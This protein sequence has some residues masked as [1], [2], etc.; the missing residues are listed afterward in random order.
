M[1][2]ENKVGKYLEG[3][4]NNDYHGDKDFLSSSQV[5]KAI[6]SHGNFN[7]YIN[8]NEPREKTIDS[9]LDQ[10]TLIHSYL[11]EPETIDTD[12]AFMDDDGRNWRTKVDR[13]YKAQFLSAAGSK[14]VMSYTA[15]KR[16]ER[17]AKSAMAHPFF[18]RLLT[19]DGQPEMSG[20][21]T[22]DFY[23]IDL[24]FRPD[25]KI[26]EIDGGPAILDVKS[27]ANIEDFER[28]AKY[29]FDYDL[30]CYLYLL[31]NHKV[32]GEPM[33]IPF[34]FGV[35]ES[36]GLYRSAVYK[37]S[38][39]FIEQGRKKYVKAMSNIQIA[40]K[41]KQDIVVFQDCDYQNI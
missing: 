26:F 23:N 29:Q 41:Q 32:T 7:Y 30:S 33:D 22:D 34:Y 37:A 5:K 40:K 1:K 24:R 6:K 11:L 27:T 18:K 17:S 36:A 3:I 8:N 4:S 25:R 35:T 19:C 38:E 14:M 12:F 13:E 31:G 20:Y 2:K 16:A 39:N 9:H 15:K 10:G 21:F 28:I